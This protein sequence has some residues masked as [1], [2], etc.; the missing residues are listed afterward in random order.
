LDSLSLQ[1]LASLT[2]RGLGVS[3]NPGLRR[4]LNGRT[5]NLGLKLTGTTHATYANNGYDAT[6]T[7]ATTA[8][9]V[10]DLRSFTNILNQPT[11]ALS[12]LRLFY[13][14]HASTSG[15]ASIK[16]GDSGANALIIQGCMGTTPVELPPG[17][18]YIVAVPSVAGVTVGATAKDVKVVAS[19]TTV[20]AFTVGWWGE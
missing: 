9:T 5:F 4:V 2:G 8:S 3:G 1:F 18:I 7:L 12:K 13:V 20:A 10:F 14:Q 17:G 11:Q 15:A 19:G 6:V 16:V